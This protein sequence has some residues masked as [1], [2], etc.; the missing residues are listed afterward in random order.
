MTRQLEGLL[1]QIE[2]DMAAQVGERFVALAARY[3]AESRSQEGSVSTRAS[4]ED[5]WRLFDDVPAAAGADMPDVLERLERA[6]DEQRADHVP[7]RRRE[8]GSWRLRPL[9]RSV[10]PTLMR[11]PPRPCSTGCSG[12]RARPPSRSP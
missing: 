2:A 1:Q 8:S 5:L 10:E 9:L 4:A 11:S 3:F 12:A 6:G 7:L